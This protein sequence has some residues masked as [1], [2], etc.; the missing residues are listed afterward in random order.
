MSGIR[1]LSFFG[2]AYQRVAVLDL[3]TGTDVDLGDRP[4]ARR[5]D[6]V[7]HLHRV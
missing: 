7:V 2:E 6:A 4:G 1:W 5:A 3:L